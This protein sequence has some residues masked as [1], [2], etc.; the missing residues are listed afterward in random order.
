MAFAAVVDKEAEQQALIR[1]NELTR[2][3][4]AFSRAFSRAMGLSTHLNLITTVDFSRRQ[5]ERLER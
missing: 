1:A 3:H 5:A 2:H 4:G